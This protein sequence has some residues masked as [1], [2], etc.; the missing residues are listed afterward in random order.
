[1]D[2]RRAAS[3]SG[4]H[5]IFHASAMMMKRHDTRRGDRRGKRH[6]LLN[7]KDNRE[8]SGKD[9]HKTA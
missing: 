3:T 7:G 6:A 4:A 8:N 1:M 2:T 5:T 9:L